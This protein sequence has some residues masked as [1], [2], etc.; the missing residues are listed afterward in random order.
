M[1]K[2]TLLKCW[3]L[4]VSRIFMPETMSSLFVVF[5]ARLCAILRTKPKPQRF[6]TPVNDFPTTPYS[7]KIS[8]LVENRNRTKTGKF[9]RNRRGL[10]SIFRAQTRTTCCCGA[11]LDRGL[12]FVLNVPFVNNFRIL[13]RRSKNKPISEDFEIGPGVVRIDCR[14]YFIPF[15]PGQGWGG[16]SASQTLRRVSQIR[17]KFK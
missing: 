16:G 13:F 5:T 3:N 2:K 12:L 7:G 1:F 14:V 10:E 17:K 6:F 4:I 15:Y 9:E 8:L 11:P